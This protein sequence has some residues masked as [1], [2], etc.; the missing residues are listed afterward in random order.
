MNEIPSITVEE[1][2]ESEV[3]SQRG[4]AA[5]G[6]S[7]RSQEAEKKG[8]WDAAVWSV[9]LQKPQKVFVGDA[10]FLKHES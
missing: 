5:K 8:A 4:S 7:F 9:A 1:E 2:D 3:R 10:L 6:S